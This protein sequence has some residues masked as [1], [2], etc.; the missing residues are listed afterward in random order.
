MASNG[1]R[2]I[3]SR[4]DKEEYYTAAFSYQRTTT[5]FINK[6]ITLLVFEQSSLARHGQL[7]EF[8]FAIC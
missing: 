5:I 1:H 2:D 6:L 3:F 8:V 4:I 7:E